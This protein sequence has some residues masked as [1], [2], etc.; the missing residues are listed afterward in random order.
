MRYSQNEQMDEKK[1]VVK[2]SPPRKRSGLFI[3]LAGVVVIFLG[4]LALFFRTN[5]PDNQTGKPDTGVQAGR[6]A[7]GVV[8]EES[9]PDA[10]QTPTSTTPAVTQMKKSLPSESPSEQTGDKGENEKTVNPEDFYTDSSLPLVQV[11]EQG[12]GGALEQISLPPLPYSIYIGAYKDFNESQTTQR[13][14]QSN[15]L[16]AYIVPVDVKGNVAQSLFGV[17]Q[18]GVWYRILVGHYSSKEEA[19]K[20]LGRMMS[21][22]PE[23]Q[24]EIMQFA[25]ALDC[26]RFFQRGN[27]DQLMEELV[28][29]N[30]FPYAQSYPTEDGRTLTRILVGCYFSSQGALLQKNLLDEQG[31][32]CTVD[33]R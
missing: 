28:Q 31:F 11:S 17:T 13:E 14:L 2:A 8:P 30:F 5:S 21:K 20:T 4:I 3:A 10:S 25:Y 19:R 1:N 24:P 23:G 29:K 9:L 32:S 12:D 15:F 22:R 27:A 26:G 16:P 7:S 33:Q 6:D 18:D